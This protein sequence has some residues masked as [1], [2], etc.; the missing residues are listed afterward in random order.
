MSYTSC[1]PVKKTLIKCLEE[2]RKN[3]HNGEIIY[4]NQGLFTEIYNLTIKTDDIYLNHI[5]D[6]FILNHNDLQELKNIFELHGELLKNKQDEPDIMMLLEDNAKDILQNKIYPS[7]KYTKNKTRIIKICEELEN[8]KNNPQDNSKE[9]CQ[10]I[11][12]YLT[13][14]L[15][16]RTAEFT[17]KDYEILATQTFT[18]PYKSPEVMR[19]FKEY[20]EAIIMEQDS[21]KGDGLIEK[22]IPNDRNL[23]NSY[24]CAIFYASFRNIL[25]GQFWPL[26]K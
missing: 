14:L 20:A 2:Y 22:F 23:P 19:F 6:L 16:C 5:S 9:K 21:T 11:Y 12:T 1:G 15:L 4:N 26:R 13:N 3:R 7:L 24:F 25:N 17:I 18:I 10:K 8:I